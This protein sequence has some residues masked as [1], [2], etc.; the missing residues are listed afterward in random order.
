MATDRDLRVL[1]WVAHQYAAQFYQV[2]QLLT[3]FPG[4]TLQ[5]DLISEAVTKDQINRWQRAGWVEYKRFL[6]VGRGWCWVTRKG[7]QMLDMEYYHAAPPAATR[8]NHLYAVNQIRLEIGV[9]YPWA[10]ERE[11]RAGLE[12][13][14]GEST[15][16]IPDAYIMHELGR[17]AI[18]AEISQKKPAELVHK[19]RSLAGYIAYDEEVGNYRTVYAAVWFFVP[20]EKLQRAVETAR[21]HLEKGLQGRIHVVVNDSLLLASR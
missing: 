4:A 20:N 8:L 6:A 10:S 19:L 15:G 3:R 14:K 9:K 13:K 18:E 17:T 21:G 7:L 2:Q 11:I 5:G 1:P 12:L 16:P